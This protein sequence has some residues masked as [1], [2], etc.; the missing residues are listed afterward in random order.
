M[1]QYALSTGRVVP[2]EVMERLDRAI[3]A[4][5]GQVAVATP[6]SGDDEPPTGAE[7]RT[8]SVTTTSRLVS[9]AAAHAGLALAIVPATPEAVR[10]IAD[11]RER[12]PLWC[13][14]GP[15]P[16]VRQML[17]LALFSLVI[18]LGVSISAVIDTANMS[19]SLLELSGYP[20]LMVE[21]FLV[22]AASLGSCFANLQRINTVVSNGT[23][24][25][26]VQSTYWTR[27]VMGV[28][29]GIVLS[30]L[31]YD[32][33]LAHLGD[34]NSAGG[35]PGAIE[36]PLLAL[37]GGYSV[38]FVH[39]VLK[40]VINTLGDFFGLAMDGPADNK[41]RAAGSEALAQRL[42]MASDL[43]DLQRALAENADMNAIRSRLESLIQ[44]IS[45]KPG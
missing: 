12:H 4:L 21:V 20:L 3:S 25:P 27:W 42:A 37:V 19:A 10:L 26:R 30:Q 11:E 1:V 14:F 38:D 6:D 35:I 13:E 28:I 43:A 41:P 23:Y 15:L 31:V 2:A 8:A 18:L 34:D 32:L 7:S 40:R 29:S 44:R 16:L 5:G 24:D 45:G 9:L 39:G 22:S 36:Q 17:G 33:F